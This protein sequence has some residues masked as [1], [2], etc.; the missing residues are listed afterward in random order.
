[1]FRSIDLFLTAD[2]SL[3]RLPGGE[4]GDREQKNRVLHGSDSSHRNAHPHK[5]FR[6][7]T[8]WELGQL[9]SRSNWQQKHA[10]RCASWRGFGTH[11]K[12]DAC[13]I[14]C[15]T[16]VTCVRLCIRNEGRSCFGLSVSGS[17]LLSLLGYFEI[18]LDSCVELTRWCV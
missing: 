12:G 13:N 14:D 10:G 17:W 7:G 1:M 2:T 6:F 3:V 9:P 4:G 8:E 5:C 18:G 16:L 15:H 11:S